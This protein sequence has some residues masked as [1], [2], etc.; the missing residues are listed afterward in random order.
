MSENNEQ[1]QHNK[2]LLEDFFKSKVY[3]LIQKRNAEHIGRLLLEIQN[4]EPNMEL[5][6]F[7][8]TRV[9]AEIMAHLSFFKYI[10]KEYEIK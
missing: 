4:H 9:R 3:E 5:N 2:E 8:T 7:N 6:H 1:T 10:K